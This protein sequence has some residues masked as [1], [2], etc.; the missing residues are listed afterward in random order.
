MKPIT[1][2]WLKAAWDDLLVIESI[3]KNASLSNMVAFH[4]QQ[5][6]EKSFKA[7]LEEK[8]KETPIKSHDLLRLHQQVKQI[9]DFQVDIDLLR[10]VNE[11]YIDSRYPGDMGLLPYGKPSIEDANEFS[12]LAR[13]IYDSVRHYLDKEV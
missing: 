4:A 11:V 13:Q 1:Y 2:E 9:N 6:I 5:A 8:K 7:V 3:I 10:S 12:I